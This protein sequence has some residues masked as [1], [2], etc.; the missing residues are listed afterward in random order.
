[1][2]VVRFGGD[3]K[4]RGKWGVK[5]R[6]EVQRRFWERRGRRG[7][8]SACGMLQRRRPVRLPEEEDGRPTDWAGLPVSDG[9][10]AG[11]TGPEGGRE[12]GGP[13]LGRKGREEA[14]RGRRGAG[15]WQVARAE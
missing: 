11:Q 15:R 4:Q 2:P 13:R 10:A 8:S 6:G 5:S 3:G 14:Q 12:R 9:E 1:M 7:G